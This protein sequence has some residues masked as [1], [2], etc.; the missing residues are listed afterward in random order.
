[1]AD[2]RK[3]RAGHAPTEPTARSSTG[4]L[5]ASPSPEKARTRTPAVEPAPESAS[6]GDSTDVGC[7]SSRFAGPAESPGLL[8]WQA[9]NAWQRKVRA[10]LEPVGV[11]HVQFVL[12]ASIGWMEH[13]GGAPTQAALARHARTDAM[14]T[15]QVLRALETRGLVTRT[16]APH[17][18][19]VRL[20]AL[21]D[22]GRTLVARAL[23]RVEAADVA[24]F[25]AAG[26]EL[27]ETV[28]LL[29]RLAGGD[30]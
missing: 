11:T 18:A 8:L 13:A 19:R 27:G 4:T 24:F 28:A 15:S 2:R 16:P 1:M 7:F 20:L 14:M 6:G 21:T 10:A 30:G 3:G 9:T 12:L 17:D 22:A 29:R 25:A 26:A 23:P 5:D